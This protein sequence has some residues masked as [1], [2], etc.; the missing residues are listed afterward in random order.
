[1]GSY[2][3]SEKGILPLSNASITDRLNRLPVT[4]LH[5]KVILIIGFA[6]FFEFFDVFLSGVL[7][8]VLTQQ[9][10]VS[11][12]VQPLLLGSAFLGMFLGALIIGNLADRIGRKKAFIVNLIIYSVFTLLGAFSN[13]ITTL[14]I[15]RFLA[16]VGIGSQPALCDT[17]LSELLPNS[18][19]GRLTAWAYTIQVCAVPVEGFLARWLV[20]LHP[21][22][23]GWRWVFIIGA[24]GGFTALFLQ[25][26]LPESPRWLMSIGKVKES[27][28]VV[29]MFEKQ[30]GHPSAG[31]PNSN[32]KVLPNSNPAKLPSVA[33]FR[34]EFIGRTAM[35]WVFQILQTIGYYGFGTLI[36]IVLAAKGI[37][38][39]H[40]L[41]YTTISFL[42]YPIGS[43]ISIP[44]I[45]RVHRKWLIV[46]AAFG[47]AV[48][49]ILFGLSVSPASILILGF[50]YTLVSNIFSNAYHVFQAEIFPTSIRATA[51][52]SAYSLSR[53]MSGLMPFILL[54]VLKLH[55]AAE[56]F[57]IVACAMV[58]IMI[59]I[60]FFGPKTTGLALENVNET[61]IHDHP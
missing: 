22:M 31:K 14:I 7:G 56:M 40:S 24:V 1:M 20:P 17:Y 28:Q 3:T 44:I 13:N 55:G 4:S 23:A 30:A 57:E 41:E 61:T 12:A 6:L 37:T 27:E 35:L 19:R 16:G 49:G 25:K 29:Q 2:E 18:K 52:G 8:T 32:T 5:K 36:P 33:L 34:K 10:H 39:I 46:G 48:F 53:L 54:P 47:M 11:S 59:D 45:E 26:Y 9:F 50:L 43:L 58:L 15:F 60:G 42:G 21:G 38:V 51:T